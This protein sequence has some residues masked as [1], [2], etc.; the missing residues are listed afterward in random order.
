[1]LLSA[2]STD[3]FA[4]YLCQPSLWVFKPPATTRDL[5]V[6]NSCAG[7]L[8]S[9]K[10][11]KMLDHLFLYLERYQVVKFKPYH[12]LPSFILG[13]ASSSSL[14]PTTGYLWF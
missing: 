12:W 8:R 5:V 10:V 13:K 7:F 14:E 4:Y 11:L 6:P 9:V 1:M 2:F 3:A